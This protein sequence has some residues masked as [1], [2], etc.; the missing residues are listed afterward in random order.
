MTI[1]FEEF[2]QLMREIVDL[3]AN[4]PLTTETYF[5]K[6]LGVTGD[7]G[8]ELLVDIENSLEIEFLTAGDNC[9]EIFGLE[10][11]QY[12]FHSEGINLTGLF[13]TLFRFLSNEP[14]TIEKYSEVQDLTV[15]KLYEVVT[16]IQRINGEKTKTPHNPCD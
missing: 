10:P 8:Y 13:E 11:G 16:R 4:Y 14:Y 15:G 1:S 3:D 7:D 6:D 9:Q 12:L 5:E 2:K